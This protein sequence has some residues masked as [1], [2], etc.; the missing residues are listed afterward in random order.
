MKSITIYSLLGLTL[1]A[2]ATSASAQDVAGSS[3]IPRNY[4]DGSPGQVY[5]YTGGSFA[6]GTTVSTFSFVNSQG[7]EGDLTPILFQETSPGEYVIRGVGSSISPT[8]SSSVQSDAF[9]LQYGTATTGAD[10]T[11]GFINSDVNGSGV[12]TST[13]SG[14]VDFGVPVSGGNGAGGAGT[15]NNWEFTPSSFSTDDNVVLGAS[16]GV[17][18]TYGL[19][20]DEDFFDDNRTYSAQLSGTASAPDASGTAL[21]LLLSSGCMGLATRMLR[22]RLA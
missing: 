13:S 2:G 7:S 15:D 19:N 3:L 8:V 14:T 4:T 10:Y 22:Q 12:Q 21:L 20:D 11:F 18:G 17:G 6:S 5:I 16:F 1:L 9:G